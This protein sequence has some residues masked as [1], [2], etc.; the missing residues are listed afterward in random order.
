V[1]E[2]VIGDGLWQQML[3]A[4]AAERYMHLHD[5]AALRRFVGACFLVLRQGCTWAEL[6]RLVPSADA[7]RKRFRRW[8][9]KGIFDRLM[10]C[11]QPRAAPDVLHID[12]T[13]IKCHRTS[14]GARGGGEQAIGRSRGGLTS[15]VHHAVDGLGFVRRVLVTPGQHADCRHAQALTEALQPVFVVGDK[16]YDADALR[17]HWCRRGIAV[18]IP[19]KRHRLV[20]HRH[21]EALYRTRHIVE[22]AFCR[23]KDF[24]R[25]SLRLDKTAT[26]FRAFACLAAALMNWRLVENLVRRA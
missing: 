3:P 5:P 20:Q 24:R 25:M 8:A 26:S 19:S 6:G 14:T 2:P 1:E 23:L 10:L 12:S 21:D 16:G 18:C 9:E 22:N 7:A 13:S 17:E 11:S 4:L 15:K